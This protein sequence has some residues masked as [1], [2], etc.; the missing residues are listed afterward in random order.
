[1]AF[2]SESDFQPGTSIGYLARRVFQLTATALEP[3][4]VPDDITMTQWSALVSIHFNSGGTCAE[5]A[6]D[7]SH[8]KGATTRLVDALVDMGL[9][10]RGRDAADRRI[11]T[12]SLT[13]KGTAIAQRA[14]SRVIDCWNDWL[15]DW[16]HD[17]ARELIRLLDK[18]RGTLADKTAQAKLGEDTCA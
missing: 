8:D 10:E 9:V 15:D 6:R 4:F 1:M 2:Y 18:L 13:A 17:E 7:L 16:D 11:V 5:L 14:R 3:V 12:L